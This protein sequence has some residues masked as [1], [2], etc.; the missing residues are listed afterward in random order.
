MALRPTFLIGGRLV[1]VAGESHYQEALRAIVGAASEGE[2]QVRHA[3]EAVLAPEPENPHDANAVLV[4]I[5]GHKVGYLPRAEAAAYGPMLK[6]LADRGRAGAAEAVVA[7]RTDAS[8]SNLGVFL[9]LP[10]PEE[11]RLDPGRRW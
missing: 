9:R 8:A 2:P 7:G 3:T 1:N 5:D 4:T 6:A 10:E 11:P